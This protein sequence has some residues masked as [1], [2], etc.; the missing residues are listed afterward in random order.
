MEICID[1]H[2][3]AIY[4]RLSGGLEI[5]KLLCP[6]SLV[7]GLAVARQPMAGS[8]GPN[9]P[10]DNRGALGSCAGC[11]C[12]PTF[13]QVKSQHSLCFDVQVD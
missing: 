1:M 12:C 10:G 6:G 7:S 13:C 4:L 8:D 2:R 3:Y 9:G 11:D 5:S